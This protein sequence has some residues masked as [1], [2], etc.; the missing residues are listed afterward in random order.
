MGGEAGRQE[1]RLLGTLSQNPTSAG[2]IRTQVVNY[3]SMSGRLR[4]V[5]RSL[6]GPERLSRPGPLVRSGPSGV[7]RES[8]P[9][10]WRAGPGRSPLHGCQ[11]RPLA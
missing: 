8:G 6:Q 7:G 4:E 11:S 10:G 1:G 3:T 5:S 9:A 2:S